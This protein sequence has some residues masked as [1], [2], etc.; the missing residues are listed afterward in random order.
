MV[1]QNYL[2]LVLLLNKAK[3]PGTYMRN[4]RPHKGEKGGWARHIS[5][6]RTTQLMSPWFSF[7]LRIQTRCW[8][9]QQPG[10]ASQDS[11]NTP[12]KKLAFSGPGPGKEQPSKKGNSRWSPW[13]SCVSWRSRQDHVGAKTTWELELMLIGHSEET[14][15]HHNL[16]WGEACHGAGPWCLPGGNELPP[17]PNHCLCG[18]SGNPVG[19]FHPTATN[20]S[21][22]L[23]GCQAATKMSSLQ[24]GL[25]WQARAVIPTQH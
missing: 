24:P 12:N 1:K 19:I 22:P 2:S 25:E 18:I 17:S 4:Q 9:K 23:H 11:Q 14:H 20:D 5:T 3:A 8:K 21:M 7:R 10:K 13:C 16:G 6:P 15:T